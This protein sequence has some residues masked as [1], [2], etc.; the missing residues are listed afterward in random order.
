MGKSQQRRLN[1]AHIRFMRKYGLRY[2]FKEPPKHE[3]AQ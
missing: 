1:E 2:E 3:K